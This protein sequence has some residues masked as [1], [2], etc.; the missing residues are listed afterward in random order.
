MRGF[1]GERCVL[2]STGSGEISCVRYDSFYKSVIR[3]L[4]NDGFDWLGRLLHTILS[5]EFIDAKALN[6]P[7]INH[8]RSGL[9]MNEEK[10]FLLFH[11]C[12]T[13]DTVLLCYFQTSMFVL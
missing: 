12:S 13:S 10:G 5:Q 6:R 9:V 7:R 2:C 1:S 8:T 3:L 11:D 4:C